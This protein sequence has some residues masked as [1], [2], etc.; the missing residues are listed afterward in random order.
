MGN[1]GSCGGKSKPKAA[2]VSETATDGAYRV[3]WPDGT[4]SFFS[5]KV[6]GQ[7]AVFRA[8][9]TLDQLPVIRNK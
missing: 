3:D 8:G 6:A 1:C 2:K 5:V 4:S 7:A 9:Y